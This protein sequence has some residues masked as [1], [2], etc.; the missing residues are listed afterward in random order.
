M[1]ITRLAVVVVAGLGLAVSGCS[2]SDNGSASGAGTTSPAVTATTAGA[3]CIVGTWKSSG[4]SMTTSTAGASGAVTGGNGLTLTVSP[5][6]KTVVDFSGMQ[7]ITFTTKVSGAEVKGQFS[8]GGKVNGAV[9]VPAG[10]EN[11]GTWEP[12]G[13]TDWSTMTITVDL[14]SPVQKRIFDNVKIADFLGS[15]SGDTG[16]A[17][18]AQPILRKGRYQCSGQTLTLSP[19]TD[20][21]AGGTWTLT[22]S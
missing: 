11:A 17:V 1:R 12:V 13:T 20:T 16:T 8:Y 3:S 5:D 15:G 18:D 21:P 19:P 14:I 2:S 4:I 9:K 22:R 6:G 7:P 10:S